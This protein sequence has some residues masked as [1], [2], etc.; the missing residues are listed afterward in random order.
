GLL[1]TIFEKLQR[2]FPATTP[3]GLTFADG[4]FAA[5]GAGPPPD[6]PQ[7]ILVTAQ[8]LVL[9][10]GLAAFPFAAPRGRRLPR[11]LWSWALT[12]LA[13]LGLVLVGLI[14]WLL[15]AWP[16]LSFLPPEAVAGGPA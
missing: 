8:W 6:L 3:A 2:P 4:N 11:R 16:A 7:S 15:Y 14:A 5:M 1:E 10:G 9:V 12:V 13:A